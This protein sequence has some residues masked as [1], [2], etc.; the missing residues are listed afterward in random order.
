MEARYTFTII[1]KFSNVNCFWCLKTSNRGTSKYSF[2][3]WKWVWHNFNAGLLSLKYIAKGDCGGFS[4][5]LQQQNC[6]SFF[7]S[8]VLWRFCREDTIQNSTIVS[9]FLP[10]YSSRGINGSIWMDASTYILSSDQTHYCYFVNSKDNQSQYAMCINPWHSFNERR[11]QK[12][13]LH[14]FVIS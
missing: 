11:L 12:C 1:I 9:Q 3:P 8:I 4:L 14:P 5:L 13:Q 2:F 10:F 7:F 6:D